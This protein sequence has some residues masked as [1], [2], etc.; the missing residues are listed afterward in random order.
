MPINEFALADLEAQDQSIA[1]DVLHYLDTL[2]GHG[3]DQAQ[4]EQGQQQEPT[5]TTAFPTK[6]TI[7][8]RA[9]LESPV[10]I[11]AAT[12]WCQSKV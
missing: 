4:K 10:K 1:Q 6:L 11:F 9:Q 2:Y 12:S 7:F 5:I 8:L 3:G